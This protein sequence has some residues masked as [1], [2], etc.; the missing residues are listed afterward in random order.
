MILGLRMFLIDLNVV[1][2]Y[3]LLGTTSSKS[4]CHPERGHYIATKPHHKS[5]N[6]QHQNRKRKGDRA[7]TWEA[8][9][10]LADGDEHDDDLQLLGL[11]QFMILSRSTCVD[12]DII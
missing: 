11:Q 4:R 3:Y 12:R 5:F 6:H 1:H 7:S 2:Y 8:K 10:T 9:E